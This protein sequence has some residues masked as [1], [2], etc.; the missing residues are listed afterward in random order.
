MSLVPN[1]LSHNRDQLFDLAAWLDSCPWSGYIA[2][3][4]CKC[5]FVVPRSTKTHRVFPQGEILKNYETAQVFIHRLQH[6]R[7][8]CW[9]FMK[10][11]RLF[12]IKHPLRKMNQLRIIHGRTGKIPVSPGGTETIVCNRCSYKVPVIVGINT[13]KK[14]NHKFYNSKVQ[15]TQEE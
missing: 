1:F 3:W 7:Q 8:K 10:R 14:W 15:A 9:K 5:L 6:Y 12:I 13:S 4:N 2:L 11:R